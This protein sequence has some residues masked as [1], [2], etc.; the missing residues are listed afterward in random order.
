MIDIADIRKYYEND[1]VMVTQHAS[2]RFRQRNIR[3][4]DIKSGIMNGEIIE[5]YTDD[6]PFPSCLIF[7][8]TIDKR[9]IHIVMSDEGTSSRI[10]TAYI[11][12]IEKW[13]DDYKTRKE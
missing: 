6:F 7:G 1:T 5:Q 8:F 10:I 13:N 2:E 11:P 12:S 3:M 9:P 4:K